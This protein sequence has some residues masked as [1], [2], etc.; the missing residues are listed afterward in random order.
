MGF[1]V[2]SAEVGV[3]TSVLRDSDMLSRHIEIGGE[4]A[5]N[6]KKALGRK[7]CRGKSQKYRKGGNAEP[8]ETYEVSKVVQ[9]R[10]GRDTSGRESFFALYDGTGGKDSDF[11][12]I[13]EFSGSTKMLGTFSQVLLDQTE[14]KNSR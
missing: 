1:I 8:S 3:L 11:S 6:E 5:R 13:L 2:E 9:F 14:K 10:Y 7:M 4:S 12:F